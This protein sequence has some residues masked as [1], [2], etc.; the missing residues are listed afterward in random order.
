MKLM[1]L[2]EYMEAY[3]KKFV[4]LRGRKMVFQDEQWVVQDYEYSVIHSPEK[5]IKA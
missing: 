5:L 1:T 2:Q 4:E 3:N